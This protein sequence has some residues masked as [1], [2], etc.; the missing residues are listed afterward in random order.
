MDGERGYSGVKGS[1]IWA[2]LCDW[3]ARGAEFP[4]QS[5]IHLTMGE[6]TKIEGHTLSFHYQKQRFTDK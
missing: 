2:S 5:P 3:F 1:E 6:E 4:L